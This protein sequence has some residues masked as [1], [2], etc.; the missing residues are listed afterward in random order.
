MIIYATRNTIKQYKVKM[1]EEL[2][3]PVNVIAKSML[4]KEAGDSLLEWGCKA[5]E[6]DENRCIQLTNFASKFTVFLIRW[7]EDD[8]HD[9]PRYLMEYIFDIYKEDAEMERCLRCMLQETGGACFSAITDRSMISTMNHFQRDVAFDG[10]RFYD[11]ISDGIM[12]TRQI[13]RDMNFDWV[14][15][16]SIGYKFPGEYFRELVTERYADTEIIHFPLGGG[17]C[18]CGRRH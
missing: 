15:V 11:Y 2:R 10:Y 17:M 16:K 1:P 6:F 12:H 7:E 3:Y 9:M 13:N 4:E 14:P 8:L 18:A 5:F